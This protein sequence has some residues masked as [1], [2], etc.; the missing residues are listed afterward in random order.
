MLALGLL[1]VWTTDVAE[2]ADKGQ[3]DPAQMFKRL[4]GNS[5]GKLSKDEL[6][7]FGA[8][9]GK[10]KGKGDLSGK[11]MER[12]DTNKDG[13]LSADEFKALGEMLKDRKKDE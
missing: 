8:K 1:L 11:L 4:D 2:A 9:L 7:K 12:L 5:D 3:R 10:D 13:F 6:A